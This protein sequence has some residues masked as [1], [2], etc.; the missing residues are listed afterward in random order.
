MNVLSTFSHSSFPSSLNSTMYPVTLD[1]PSFN[2]GDH[3][4]STD[5]F[6]QSVTLG[7][8]GPGG[9][10]KNQYISV[11]LISMVLLETI[12]FLKND[13]KAYQLDL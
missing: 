12:F 2:G 9:A 6:V 7:N 13:L 8:G 10:G 1:P 11:F 4:K 3:S 5:D